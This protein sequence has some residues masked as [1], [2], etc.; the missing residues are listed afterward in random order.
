MKKNSLFLLIAILIIMML[1]LAACGG[2]NDETVSDN[3]GNE[4]NGEDTTTDTTEEPTDEDANTTDS[5]SDISLENLASAQ[6]DIKSYHFKQT[7]D[8]NGLNYSIEVYYKDNKMKTVS[9]SDGI[10]SYTYLD[11][12]AGEMIVYTPSMGE[13]AMKMPMD[14]NSE[15][16]P[17]NPLEEDYTL[18]YGITGEENIDGYNCRVLESLD[19][20]M[21]M[22]IIEE[23]GFPIK[24][25]MIDPDS[26]VSI[27]TK[28]EELSFNDVTDKD[29]AVPADLEIMDLNDM[30]P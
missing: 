21:K 13:Q 22:W 15:E 3:S 29:V 10:E 6:K 25:E 12:T 24:I 7:V 2:S 18:D 19:G 9:A 14:A 17:S 8:A 20:N 11:L 5:G 28:Y 1:A 27:V 16:L 30:M 4:V 23:Y 26:G